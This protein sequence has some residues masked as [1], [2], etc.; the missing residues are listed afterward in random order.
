MRN[1]L[2]PDRVQ[3]HAPS[4]CTDV[5]NLAEGQDHAEFSRE[6]LAIMQDCVLAAQCITIL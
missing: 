3:V 5:H 1:V 4:G 6:R 2:L